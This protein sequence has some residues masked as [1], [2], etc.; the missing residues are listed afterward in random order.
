MNGNKPDAHKM[1]GWSNLETSPPSWTHIFYLWK[2]GKIILG[3]TVCKLLKTM[4][5]KKSVRVV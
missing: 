5:G 3:K 1:Q 2:L 4:H